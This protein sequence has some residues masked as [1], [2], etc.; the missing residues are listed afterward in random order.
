[1]HQNF[2]FVLAA[3]ILL[4]FFIN[5]SSKSGNKNRDIGNN[6]PWI[7]VSS[8][9]IT[10]T[11]SPNTPGTWIPS[12]TSPISWK[13]GSSDPGDI[14]PSVYIDPGTENYGLSGWY[15]KGNPFI[16]SPLGEDLARA[17][18]SQNY[19]SSNLI[20][21]SK[22]M[23]NLPSDSPLVL[24]ISFKNV[25][26]NTRYRISFNTSVLNAT[27]IFEVLFNGKDLLFENVR[28][29]WSLNQ[30]I[31]TSDNDDINVLE[32]FFTRGTGIVN[33]VNVNLYQD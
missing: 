14:Y 27:S 1:M 16:V 24:K 26:R 12:S 18:N 31:I 19:D 21:L 20:D 22:V 25:F 2:L 6:P 9:S 17:I 29:Y 33:I 28:N 23:P 13:F 3:L 11:P 5:Y 10:W 7:P 4:F 30:Q 15:A 32:I 8:S